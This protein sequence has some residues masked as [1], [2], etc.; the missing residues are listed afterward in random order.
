MRLT[1]D[2]AKNARNIQERGLPF[3]MVENFDWQHA[4]IMEDTR[5]DY[6]ERRFRAFGKIEDRL[7]AVVFTPRDDALHIISFRKTN[8]REEKRYGQSN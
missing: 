5:Q 8:K 3:T 1:F 7:F 2:P 4:L 6:G